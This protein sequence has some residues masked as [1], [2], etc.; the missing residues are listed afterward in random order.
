MSGKVDDAFGNHIKI[1]GFG[2]VRGADVA[3]TVFVRT[4]DETSA[5]TVTASSLQ[6]TEVGRAVAAAVAQPFL[7]TPEF[8]WVW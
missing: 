3:T 5:Q 6:I 8:C 2:C 1:A 7:T 4:I